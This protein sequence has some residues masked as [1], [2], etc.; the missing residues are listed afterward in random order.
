M[1]RLYEIDGKYEQPVGR[2][3]ADSIEKLVDVPPDCTVITEG[4]N[5]K[6]VTD[7]AECYSLLFVLALVLVSAGS[8]SAQKCLC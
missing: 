5:L 4:S 6:E 7:V 2:S 1:H 8:V 3:G